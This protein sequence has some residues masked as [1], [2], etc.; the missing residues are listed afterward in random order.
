MI[1]DAPTRPR[2][3]LGDVQD[4]STFGCLSWPACVAGGTLCPQP[5]SFGSSL[6]PC[7]HFSP[8]T[9]QCPDSIPPTPNT[10]GSYGVTGA[11]KD[12]ITAAT[13]D[14]TDVLQTT[15]SDYFMWIAL[16]VITTLVVFQE[17]KK[18]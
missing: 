8:P 4:T 3:R 18:T 6:N 12:A 15:A 5:D 9:G 13:K 14:A 17:F 2:A 16:A 11:V 7:C 1:R 10:D